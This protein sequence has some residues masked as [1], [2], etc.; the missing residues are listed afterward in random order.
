MQ[1]LSLNAMAARMLETRVSDATGKPF[2]LAVRDADLHQLLQSSYESSSALAATIDYARSGRVFDA[3]A[4]RVSSGNERL[5]ILVIRDVTELRRLENVRREF[6]ANVS[7]ELRTPLASIRA[8]VE[9]LEAGAIDDPH[10]S[11][12]FF[13]RVIGEVDRLTALVD[14]LLDLARLESGRITL[15][16]ADMAPRTLVEGGADRLRA[17]IERARLTLSVEVAPDLPTVTV[18]RGRIEQVLLNLI[19]NAIKFTPPGGAITVRAE[20][21]ADAVAI[22]V[23]DT[24]SG[25]SAAEMPRVF[26]RFYK[27]D[28]A[29][30]SDGTGLGLAIA[31]HIVHAHGGTIWVESAPGSGSTFT[32]TLPVDETAEAREADRSRPGVHAL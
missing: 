18:D 29:R 2:M 28:K 16:L 7:H 14:E 17:Q 31:K 26:E 25:I 13:G 23:I 4:Q 20:R 19:H 1:V 8:L 12:D 15:K 11:R 5:G 24:G 3:V 6:V 21:E 32:F 30:R 27:S 9:T 22:S 10:V